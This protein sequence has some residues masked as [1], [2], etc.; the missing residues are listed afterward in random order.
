MMKKIIVCLIL[1][2][3]FGCI[4]PPP[5]KEELQERA[6]YGD[7]V[8]VNYVLWVDGKVRDSNIESV[9]QEAGIYNPLRTY[10]PL[11]VHLMLGPK[12]PYIPG[13]VKAIVGMKVN[14]TKTVN[15]SPE[16]AYGA[17]NN[18]LVYEVPLYYNKSMLEEVPL[19]Y[20]EERNITVEE[21]ASFNSDIG[22]VFIQNY[23]NDTVTIA[24]FFNKGDV[25]N[26]MGIPQVVVDFD[27][28]TYTIKRD[29]KENKTYTTI[30]PLTGRAVTLR[31]AKV[32]NETF[33][34][35]ENHPLAGKT[36]VYNLTL[37]ELGKSGDF[38]GL[39]GG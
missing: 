27:N 9:A 3:F 35:D 4:N 34:V 30:S 19:S 15:I 12:N 38:S 28:L 26:Y 2:L 20:F 18:S 17:Y 14:E 10:K 29:V 1:F 13:F 8:L 37:V 21:G 11:R 36:L 24:Y 16:E 31:V 22:L 7:V 5:E 6:E 23:T 39:G 25:F 33:T 32:L